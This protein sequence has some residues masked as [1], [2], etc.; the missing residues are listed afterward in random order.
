MP[1]SLG[2]ESGTGFA[3]ITTPSRLRY[4]GRSDLIEAGGV[5]FDA[6][7]STAAAEVFAFFEVEAVGDLADEAALAGDGVAGERLA[8]EDG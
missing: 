2:G 7:L 6:A 1:G 3:L 4:T 8:G 5:V